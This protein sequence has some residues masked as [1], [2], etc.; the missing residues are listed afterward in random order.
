MGYGTKK[1]IPSQAT[2]GRSESKRGGVGV[3]QMDG[4]AGGTK[5]FNTGRTEGVCYSHNRKAYKKEDK[6]D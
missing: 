3:G 6:A 2:Y 4:D 1:S 5:T